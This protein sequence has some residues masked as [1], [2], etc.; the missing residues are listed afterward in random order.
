MSSRFE[1]IIATAVVAGA[2][3]LTGC[4]SEE[5]EVLPFP[6]TLYAQPF[7]R[8]FPRRHP[9]GGAEQLHPRLLCI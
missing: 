4:S 2:L 1:K 8:I 9:S 3:A 7:R 6:N 5:E